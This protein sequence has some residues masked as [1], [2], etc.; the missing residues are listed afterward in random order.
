MIYT[1]TGI[2]TEDVVKRILFIC[3]SRTNFPTG[4]GILQV[5]NGATEQQ[6][7]DGA[8]HKTDY[9]GGRIGIRDENSLDADYVFGRMMKIRL[10]WTDSTVSISPD[11]FRFDYQSW[12]SQKDLRNADDLMRL[13]AK[14]LNFKWASEGALKTE[15]L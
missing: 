7:F 8:Y 9:P 1:V 14:E 2:S 13:A 15:D 10:A 11:S 12:M 6:V 3:Y 5:R 4:M